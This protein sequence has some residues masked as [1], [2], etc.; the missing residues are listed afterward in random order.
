MSGLTRVACVHAHRTS[1]WPNEPNVKLG[2]LTATIPYGR[3]IRTTGAGNRVI[4]L[5][6]ARR[7][8]FPF[9]LVS[10]PSSSVS[11]Q[12]HRRRVMSR[13]RVSPFEALESRV[14]MAG[15]HPV[16]EHG[17]M[18]VLPAINAEPMSDSDGTGGPVQ[19]SIVPAYSSRPGATATI[20][21]DFDGNVET[22]WG[23][24]S[25]VV[26]PEFNTDSTAGFSASE[27]QKIQ[28]IWRVVAEDYAP[29]NI[30]VTTVDPG[31]F[32]NGVAI[33]V[34]IGGGTWF[35]AA[36]GV[37]YIN[38][39]TN[40]ASNTV[41][42]FNQ[43]LANNAKY[44][45][46]AAS[47]EAGHALGLQ[48]QSAY[49]GTTKTADYYSGTGDG[50]AP[51]MGNSYSAT[52]G[53]WW[54][55]TS[56]SSTTYQD[57]M[58]VI[59]R[60]TNG[61]G[62]RVDDY[63]SNAASAFSLTP[64]G[65]SISASGVI[66]QTT[67]KDFFAFSTAAGSVT[68]S[69]TVPSFNNLD[70]RL[71]LWTADGLTLLA[72][73]D[74]SNSFG[75]S[76]TTTLA[77][78]NYLIAVASHGSYG[79]VGTYTLSGTIVSGY[80]PP[81]PVTVLGP[82]GFSATAVGTTAN[83]SWLDNADNETG[84]VLQRS[85]NS[86][87]T[88]AT[89]INLDS[90]ATSFTDTGLATDTTYH[91]RLQA[92]D[93]SVFSSYA[94]GSASTQPAE[95]VATATAAGTSQVNLAWT[96]PNTESGFRVD[97]STDGGAT[98]T[99]IATLG[100]NVTSY[101]DSAC[102]AGTTYAYRVVSLNGAG[103]ATSA[104]ASATTAVSLVPLAPSGLTHTAIT[105]T[106]IT[107]TWTDNATNESGYVVQRSA[108]GGRSWSTVVTLKANTTQRT[109]GGLSRNKTYSFRVR[110]TNAYGA[111]GWSNVHVATTPR[112]AS[113]IRTVVTGVSDLTKRLAS[114]A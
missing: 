110:A 42:V 88:G 6:K 54:N 89:T 105:R 58:T 21:L 95:V 101:A 34:S 19:A 51:I 98:W 62:Y 32:G 84:Y 109:V 114:L 61:F 75:G 17:E 106:N 45:G 68:L 22:S 112:T 3:L 49:S 41:Y 102:S 81:T 16:D 13:T 83:L 100:A 4:G 18:E 85:T 8:I 50:R 33:K 2:G 104:T 93:G 82:T 46:D 48:H 35:G 92:T 31:I 97:R 37:G 91:Y 79:D 26:T 103:S 24:Y 90:D 25:N 63:G 9:A 11:I 99:N 56:T 71:E 55:G 44:I 66:T 94:S 20:Y 5:T 96:N 64:A 30:N 86:N 47:H 15:H 12:L 43:Y 29:F 27:L 28:D 10:D 76:I 7:R 52:R 107:L 67:D 57:D 80:V 59:A 111:S 108:N 60:S 38:G 78:G 23:G 113:F 70:G 40:S 36:G 87:F 39:F 53:L 74:S 77:S 72:S 73:S 14:L 1:D 69:L 65:T